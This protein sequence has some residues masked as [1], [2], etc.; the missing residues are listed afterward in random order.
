MNLPNFPNLAKGFTFYTKYLNLSS[1]CFYL[2]F[3]TFHN[4]IKF[5]NFNFDI[6]KKL[7]ILTEFVKLGKF[8]EK[9]HLDDLNVYLDSQICRFF[10]DRQH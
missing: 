9:V 2:T 7:L 8:V 4:K 3:K 1:K 6:F 5:K 10:S